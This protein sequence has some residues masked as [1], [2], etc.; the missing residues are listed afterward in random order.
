MIKRLLDI[1][2]EDSVTIYLNIKPLNGELIFNSSSYPKAQK[3]L[4]ILR[5]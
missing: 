4:W 1:L 3:P 2:F 5:H